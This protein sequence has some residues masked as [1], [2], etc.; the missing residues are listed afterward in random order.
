MRR[1]GFTLVE[2]LVVIGIISL[3]ISILLP[4][5]ARA[6]ESA[7]Q[8][9]CL[10]QLRQIGTGLIMYDQEN[11]KLPYQL[12]ETNAAGQSVGL[13]Q[14]GINHTWISEVSQL[15]GT[16]K[17]HPVGNG[18]WWK[19]SPVFRCPDALSNV[20][21]WWAPVR[22]TYQA[23]PRLMP[24]STEIL[25]DPVSNR[26]FSRRALSSVKNG[27][28]KIL[29]WDA[30]VSTDGKGIPI[31]YTMYL[32]WFVIQ[33]G[34]SF[35]E[36]GWA[37]PTQNLDVLAAAG[38]AGVSNSVNNLILDNHDYD[39]NTQWHKTG[40]RYRHMGNKNITLLFADGHAEARPIGSVTTRMLCVNWQ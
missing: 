5:L 18:G 11:K 9:A 36:P 13:W 21:E 6:R 1:R 12:V 39:V 20:D 4:S 24:L 29:V 33:W 2:L 16:P 14:G 17:E 31:W 30:S 40:M 3:L 15:M 34:H 28:D 27:S 32:E 10:S 23:N 22:F 8:V 26:G 19:S 37:D 38:Y 25:T 7:T 35:C